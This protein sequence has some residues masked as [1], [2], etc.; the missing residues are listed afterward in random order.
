MAEPR[1]FYFETE[2]IHG[3]SVSYILEDS[4]EIDENYGVTIHESYVGDGVTNV[5]RTRIFHAIFIKSVNTGGWL[6][7]SFRIGVQESLV[8][9]LI[10]I[11]KNQSKLPAGFNFVDS[12]KVL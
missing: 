7:D 11:S 2:N 3:D 4:L 9:L 1:Y 10:P 6:S 5:I 12:H 8:D